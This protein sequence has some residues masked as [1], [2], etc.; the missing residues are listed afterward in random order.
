MTRWTQMRSW[1]ARGWRDWPPTAELARAG[2][3]VLLLDQEPME[4]GRPGFLVVRRPVPGRQPG[5]APDG[6]QGLPR[7]GLAGLDGQR[8]LRPRGR[9]SGGR[10]LLGRAVGRRPTWLRRRGEAV[11]HGMGVRWLPLVGWAE[12]GGSSL[13][14]GTAVFWCPASPS[15]GAPAGCRRAFERQVRE[16]AGSGLAGLRFRH[17][18]DGLTVTR[19]TVD[20]VQGR[21]H[22][23]AE[24]GCARHPQLAR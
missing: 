24:P 9:R 20:G 6:H 3:R 15:P 1:W 18:V 5:A 10:R 14:G 11:L 7:A 8:V 23:R 19:G 17:R 12:R 16:A 21:G 2:R 4:P 22:P 13:R